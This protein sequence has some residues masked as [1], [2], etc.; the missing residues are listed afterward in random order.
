MKK[1]VWLGVA[2]ICSASC[3]A[4]AEVTKAPV[5][6]VAAEN[7]LYAVEVLSECCP[8]TAPENNEEDWQ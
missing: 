3:L 1:L 4:D 6:S 7:I 2:A 8:K 5:Q